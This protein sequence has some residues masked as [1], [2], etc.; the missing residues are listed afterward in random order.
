MEIQR[1]NTTDS[2]KVVVTDVNVFFDIISVNALPEFFAL[3]YEI[4]TTDFVIREILL[5]EQKEQIESFIRARK[6]IVIHLTPDEVEEVETF[7]LKRFFKGITD[8]TVLWKAFQL[9]CLL[10]TGDKKLRSEA[11]E[12]GIEVHGSLWVIKMLVENNIIT[13]KKG[14]DLLNHLKE[15]NGRLPNKEIDNLIAYLIK[16]LK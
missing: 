14:I 9:K 16:L 13:S 7:K 12:Q 11:E 15:L 4:N 6:L 8:K 5:S 2:M 10:L 3:D 1:T